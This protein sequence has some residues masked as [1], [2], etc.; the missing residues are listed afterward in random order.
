M[1]NEHQIFFSVNINP[2]ILHSKHEYSSHHKYI[3]LNIIFNDIYRNFLY[4][5]VFAIFVFL[6]SP[7]HLF[8]IQ[9][10]SKRS[11]L[12]RICVKVI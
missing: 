8:N 9:Y 2:V 1:T 3:N 7:M 10:F 6:H 12:T 4:F 5:K 11:S